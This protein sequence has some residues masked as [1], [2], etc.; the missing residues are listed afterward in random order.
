MVK[1]YTTMREL[2]TVNGVRMYVTVCKPSRRKAGVS[3]QKGKYT[4]HSVGANWISKERGL[5]CLAVEKQTSN[6]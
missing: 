5:S 2:R 3:I 1:E 6:Y 4:R